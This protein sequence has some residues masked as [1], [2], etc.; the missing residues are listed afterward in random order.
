MA[1]DCAASS[2]LA[3]LPS[4]VIPANIWIT[5]QQA[6]A[7]QVRALDYPVRS[8][9][10]Q[11]CSVSNVDELAVFED[12]EGVFLRQPLQLWSAAHGEKST[13]MSI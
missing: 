9:V 4:D 13:R 2:P 5:R 8:S 11:H 12:W 3:W 6:R 10:L 7:D 1:I